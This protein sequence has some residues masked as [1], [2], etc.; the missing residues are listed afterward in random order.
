MTKFK[1]LS[2]KSVN[3]TESAILKDWKKKNR[4]QSGPTAQRVISL[5]MYPTRSALPS[6][7]FLV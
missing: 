6:M 2:K 7:P 3:E 1:E 5:P 4:S